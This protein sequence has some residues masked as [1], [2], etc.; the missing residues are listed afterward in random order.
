MTNNRKLLRDL[1]SGRMKLKDLQTNR[2]EQWINS[3][4]SPYVLRCG[5]MVLDAEALR[6]RIEAYRNRIHF[7]IANVTEED[8]PFEGTPLTV[9]IREEPR[10]EALKVG[11][12]TEPK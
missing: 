11:L 10:P 1:V 3:A 12:K 6:E 7:V 2:Y 8:I 9:Q 5:A 4:N